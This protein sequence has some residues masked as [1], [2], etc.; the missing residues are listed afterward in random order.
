MLPSVV[1]VVVRRSLHS[2][3]YIYLYGHEDAVHI[4]SN[5]RSYVVVLS[6]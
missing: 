5:I 3:K 4:V 1:S 2:Y 6:G